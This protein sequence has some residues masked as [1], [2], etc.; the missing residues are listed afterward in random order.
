M[1]SGTADLGDIVV[2]FRVSE[3]M[4]TLVGVDLIT[5][6]QQKERGCHGVSIKISSGVLHKIK[7]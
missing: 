7:I 4:P 1:S 6:L 2:Q 5:Q 3:T